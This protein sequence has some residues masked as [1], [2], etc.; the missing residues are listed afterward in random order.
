MQSTGLLPSEWEEPP[1]QQKTEKIGNE[2]DKH[3]KNYFNS[4]MQLNV[5]AELSEVGIGSSNI[6][7]PWSTSNSDSLKTPAGKNV[8]LNYILGL[9][10]FLKNNSDYFRR[11]QSCF[12]FSP[13][14]FWSGGPYDFLTDPKLKEAIGEYARDNRLEETHEDEDSGTGE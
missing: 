6:G 9:L 11:K 12:V 7:A 5:P 13:M 3:F 10:H 2:F 8:R 14:T 1:T 4:F